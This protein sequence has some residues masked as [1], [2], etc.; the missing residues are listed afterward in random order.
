M[1]TNI[2]IDDELM[3]RALQVSGCKTK[4]DV[5]E[6]ALQELI[7]NHARMDLADL[8]GKITFREGYDYLNLREGR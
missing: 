1:R 2:V 3:K 4:K 6:L 8:K 7:I 5:V